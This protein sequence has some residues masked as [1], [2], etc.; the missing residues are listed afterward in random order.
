[1]AKPRISTFG[2]KTRNPSDPP[3]A[4][5]PLSSTTGVDT[6]PACVVASNVTASVSVG[7]SDPGAIVHTPPE[8]PDSV[9]G[10]EKLMVSAPANALASWIA[11]RSVHCGSPWELLKPVSQSASP[12]FA[13]LESDVEFTTNVN[14]PTA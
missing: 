2:L 14:G 1:M 12:G 7:Y 8:W 5:V 3:P 6:Y 11:A 10:M 13:S 9:A 4:P